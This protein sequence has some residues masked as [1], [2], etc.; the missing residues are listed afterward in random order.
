[1]AHACDIPVEAE[2]G[3]I[4]KMGES[5]EPG[6]AWKSKR[7]HGCSRGSSKIC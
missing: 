5:D 3:Q 7:E 1:M 2:L 6:V 4:G